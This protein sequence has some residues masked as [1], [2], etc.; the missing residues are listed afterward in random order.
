MQC[1]QWNI[2]EITFRMHLHLLQTPQSKKQQKLWKEKNP[3][4]SAEWQRQDRVKWKLEAMR[5]LGGIK[6]SAPGCKISDPDMLEID[7][8][9]NDGKNERAEVAGVTILRR[10]SLQE[11][12]GRYQV[13]CANHH[14]KKHLIQLREKR[15]VKV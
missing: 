11:N 13:L 10:I 7:H 9:N 5:K 3:N 15:N 4:F 1:T 12:Q 6:C 14:R 2:Y 8:V